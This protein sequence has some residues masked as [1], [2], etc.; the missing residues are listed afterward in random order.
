[1]APLTSC[2]FS[3]G[4]FVSIFASIS[5][6]TGFDGS[7]FLRVIQTKTELQTVIISVNIRGGLRAINVSRCPDNAVSSSRIY[8]AAI[9]ENKRPRQTGNAL[10]RKNR[11]R[12]MPSRL[13]VYIIARIDKS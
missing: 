4:S 7:F 12:I 6:A 3:N 5:D 11:L 2:R 8:S 13:V 1:M 9:C 10:R